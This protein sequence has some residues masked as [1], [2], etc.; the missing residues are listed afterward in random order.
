MSSLVLSVP[1]KSFLAGEYLALKGGPSLIFASKPRFEL[2]ASKGSG[3]VEGFHPESPAGKL[4]RDHQDFFSQQDLRFVDPHAGRGGW[5]ASTAQFLT[6]FVLNEWRESCE[7]E[8]L[9]SLSISRLLE[10]YWKYAWD[11]QGQRPSGS[12]LVAQYKGSLTLFEKRTGIVAVHG[13][14]FADIDFALIPTNHKLATHEHL[15]VLPDFDE[16][17]IEQAMSVIRSAMQASDSAEFVKGI[18]TNAQALADLGLVASH[19]K[20]LC[21]ELLQKPGVLAAKGC[22]AMGN[23]VVLVVYEKS[24]QKDFKDFVSSKDLTHGLEI[25]V[26]E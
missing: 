12:D 24:H 18:R 15:K 17:T 6:A 16:S 26:K 20:D 10:S 11:G 3:K 8:T 22:G 19:T 1:G 5:G 7:L 13:W 25:Q 23:D 14:T 21:K 9:K 2:V 4:I